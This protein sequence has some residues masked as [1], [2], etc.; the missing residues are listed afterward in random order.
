MKRRV[1][2]GRLRRRAGRKGKRLRRKVRARARRVID[3]SSRS[4]C[5]LRI[6]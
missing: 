2:R 3:W 4:V 1:V 5:K 6:F